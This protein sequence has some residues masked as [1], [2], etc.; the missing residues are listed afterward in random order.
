MPVFRRFTADLPG[1]PVGT[2]RATPSAFGGDTAAALQGLG[3]QGREIGQ[4]LVQVAEMRDKREAQ[5]QLAKLRAAASGKLDELKQKGEPITEEFGQFLNAELQELQDGRSTMEGLSIVQRQG[6]NLSAEL[7]RVARHRDAELAGEIAQNHVDEKL[8]ADG[9]ALQQTPEVLP[10][11]LDEN[12]EFV[13]T[14]DIP[15]P[16]KDAVLREMN[17][18]AAVNSVRGWIDLDP[19]M[20][21]E[22][23]QSGQFDPHL[24]PDQRDSLIGNARTRQRALET[25]HRAERAEFERRKE[26]TTERTIS[27][28]LLGVHATEEGE[29]VTTADI[30]ARSEQ[31]FEDGE[32]VI[33]PSWTIRL[34]EY[35][36]QQAQG[37][38][39]RTD[40]DTT[41]WYFRNK[42]S[43]SRQDLLERATS[44]DSSI[45]AND[46][47]RWIGQVEEGDTPLRSA[48]STFLKNAPLM[49][50]VSPFAF[51]GEE[52]AKFQLKID[53]LAQEREQEYRDDGKNPLQYYKSGEALQDAVDIAEE[54]GLVNEEARIESRLRALQGD[55]QVR[56]QFELGQQEMDQATGKPILYI[57]G[58]PTSEDSWVF[59]EEVR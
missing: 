2:P 43:L 1:A 17:S 24:T 30:L 31:R 53:I 48:R 59:A 39:I 35:K 14:L 51:E 13:E 3:R 12:R 32:P 54:T 55:R 29:R 40:M 50:G 9:N 16:Q 41:L 21:E 6:A 56:G 18:R 15:K 42:D 38:N 5:V 34:L 37:G 11:V 36:E 22:K 4:Q 47:E 49:A 58:D 19:A 20:A 7:M 46:L 33:P 57:G 52:H 23:L 8:Q 10:L 26:L 27:D 45:A 25:Q 44:P 28:I